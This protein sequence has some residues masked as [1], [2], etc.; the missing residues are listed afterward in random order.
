MK[1]YH[2]KNQTHFIKV[3]RLSGRDAY[4]VECRRC[5]MFWVTGP[6]LLSLRSPESDIAPLRPYLSAATRQAY[7]A[8]T[9]AALERDTV[10]QLAESHSKTGLR[11]K[12]TKLLHV[13][14]S[15][16]Q[17][18]GQ[19]IEL[20]SSLD[21]PLIDAAGIEEF[22]NLRSH[23]VNEDLI[24]GEDTH[25]KLTMKGWELVSP[26]EVAGGIPGRCFAA[27]AFDPSMNDA[28]EL[29][30]KAAIVEDCKLPEPVRLDRVQHN[31]N[32]SNRILADIRLSQFV[33]ADFTFQRG[34][35][36]FE[37][38]FAMA[39]GRP[40]IWTCRDDWFKET[41]FDTQQF[42]H[43]VWKDVQELRSNLRDR[44]LATISIG[45]K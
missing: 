21:Y 28:Y 10:R 35:V 9:I 31:D 45:K 17:F 44:I 15:N 2:E 27:M 19:P 29:G 30:I 33:V 25:S 36:Y 24:S 3:S 40:V 43:I 37:A 26:A 23:L 32:I 13:I 14:A 22:K 42:N 7:E 18:F 38:G 41:H 20:S 12:V 34:G 6:L 8:G 1:D 39:L 11:D 16:T 5:G 4:Q